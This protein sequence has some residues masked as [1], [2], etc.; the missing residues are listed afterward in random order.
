MPA[1]RP[2]DPKELAYRVPCELFMSFSAN[3]QAA[4]GRQNLLPNMIE[5][6]RNESARDQHSRH[7]LLAR[8]GLLHNTLCKSPFPPSPAFTPLPSS[9]PGHPN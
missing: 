2:D 9:F 1:I 4:I 7:C 5:R 6:A 8:Y 3:S